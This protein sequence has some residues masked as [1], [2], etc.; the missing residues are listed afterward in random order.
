MEKAAAPQVAEGGEKGNE[1]EKEGGGATTTLTGFGSDFIETETVETENLTAQLL[2]KNK[3][4]QVL[5]AELVELRD[6]KR[7]F[8]ELTLTL[9]AKAKVQDEAQKEI[10]MLRE[11]LVK[12]KEETKAATSLHLEQEERRKETKRENEAKEKEERDQKALHDLQEQLDKVQQ[13]LKETQNGLH[14]EQKKVE[15]LTKEWEAKMRQAEEEGKN[16]AEQL[17]AD[18]KKAESKRDE[19]ELEE[20]AAQLHGVKA[21]ARAHEEKLKEQGEELKAREAELERMRK[22]MDAALKAKEDGEGG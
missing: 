13:E 18:L 20:Q 22:A 4:L 10:V 2:E 8:D 17:L 9:E 11:E 21:E 5:E 14:L 15:D 1:K 19:V 7:Q 3:E 12:A 6:I 16:R